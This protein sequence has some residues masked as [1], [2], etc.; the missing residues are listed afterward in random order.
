[1]AVPAGHRAWKAPSGSSY[2]RLEGVAARIEELRAE[3]ADRVLVPAT[4]DV[5]TAPGA[6]EV[7]ATTGDV[8]ILVN[9]LG[10]FGST[11]PLEIDGGYV[12]SIVP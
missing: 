2:V 6:A 4:G 7:L 9:N 10:V 12:D 1:M 11:P 8:D 3:S 5:T